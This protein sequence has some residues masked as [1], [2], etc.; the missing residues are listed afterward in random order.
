M[1]PTQALLAALKGRTRLINDTT[2]EVR[3]LLTRA[4]RDIVATLAAAPTDYQAWR[5]PQLL[6]EIRRVLAA[7]GTEAA[8]VAVAGQDAAWRGGGAMVDD[9]LAA[10]TAAPAAVSVRALLPAIDTTQLEAMRA[11]LSEKISGVP[12]EAINAINTE[13]GLVTIGARSPFDAVKEV[14]AILKADTLRRATTIVHTELGRAYSTAG[15]IRM[16]QAAQLV[17]GLRKRWIW[18]GKLS[19]RPEH[20]A[21]NGDVKPVDKPFLLEGGQVQMMYPHDPSA[22]ARHTINCG[23]VSVPVLDDDNPYKLKSTIKDP[24]ADDKRR[25]RAALRKATSPGQ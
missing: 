2:T 11:F 17:P 13:L 15:Q 5:L 10:L 20:L 7:T 23:C 24:D 18:S 6:A 14:S 9:T 8:A 19:P 22:P 21:I 12:L 16:E 4:E 3:A 1:T 25:S